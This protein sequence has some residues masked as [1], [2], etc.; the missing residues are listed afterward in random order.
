MSHLDT[1]VGLQAALSELAGIR[2]KLDGIPD[3]MAEIHE[4]Y[5]ARKQEIDTEQ[6][7]ADESERQRREAEAALEDAQEKLKHYQSQV[8]QVTTQ[9]EYGALLKEIDTTKDTIKESEEKAMEAMEA[10][11]ASNAK[12]EKLKQEFSDLEERYGVE[13]EKWEAEKP[14]LEARA[15]ELESQSEALR[16]EVPRPLLSLFQRIFDRTNGDGMAEVIRIEIP[17]AG[18]MWHCSSCNFN[19]R[20]QTAVL[21]REGEI[22]H[23][24]SCKRILFWQDEPDDGEG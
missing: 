13:L 15:Q 18:V 20:P 10:T 1:I 19:V 24:D 8:G 12:V 9:R 7:A 22:H 6:E 14:G 11:E 21:V 17:R 5:S 16:K 2:E 23:C 3:W 4:E